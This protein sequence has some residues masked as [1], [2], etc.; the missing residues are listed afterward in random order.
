VVAA[1]LAKEVKAKPGAHS[2]RCDDV[3][4]QAYALKLT[5]AGLKAIAVDE[6]EAVEGASEISP[7]APGDGLNDIVDLDSAVPSAVPPKVIAA[8]RGG[9]KLAEGQCQSNGGSPTCSATA[10]SQAAIYAARVRHLSS[11]AKRLCL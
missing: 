1:G 9:S 4:K 6:T 8:P 2:W 10:L 7:P 3:T 11:A 5:P